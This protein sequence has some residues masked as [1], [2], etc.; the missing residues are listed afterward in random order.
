MWANHVWNMFDF[1]ADARNQGGEPGMNHKGLVT[2]DRKIKKDSFYLY[3]AYWS[4]EGFV[5]IAGSRYVDRPEAVTKVKVYSNQPKVSLYNNG[6][7]VAE[8]SGEHVFTF[9]VSLEAEN[10]LKAVAGSFEDTAF[11]RKVDKPNPAYKL[12]VKS[13]N[14]ANWV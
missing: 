11:I 14:S 9:E 4:E 7:L 6:K 2:F 8:K 1:A 13:S 12:N 10:N 5:H 3:K